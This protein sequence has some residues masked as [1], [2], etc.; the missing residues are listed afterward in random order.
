MAKPGHPFETE[1]LD[2]LRR[3][4]R[5]TLRMVPDGTIANVLQAFSEGNRE[6]PP[7]LDRAMVELEL[8]RCIAE[9][10]RAA[11]EAVH[12]GEA[13]A[14]M[15]TAK[16]LTEN[17]PTWKT[18]PDPLDELIAKLAERGREPV[19][20]P[21]SDRSQVLRYV[22]LLILAEATATDDYEDPRVK[23]D[24]QPIAVY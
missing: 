23:P 9:E 4:Q 16:F 11:G 6:L 24:V 5:R 21:G 10:E 22:A 14:A 18:K 12:I 17:E 19:R 1:G 15:A 7:E 8:R 13:E 3:S 2:E 20:E